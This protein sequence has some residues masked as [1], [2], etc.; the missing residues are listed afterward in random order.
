MSLTQRRRA[1][2]PCRRD[3]C[4]RLSSGRR[5]R[6]LRAICVTEVTLAVIGTRA[7]WTASPSAV[8][9]A[10]ADGSTLLPNG[11]R[12]SPAGKH[13]KVGDL[14][15]NFLQTP[16]S[17]YLIVTT[18]GLARPTFSIIDVASWTVKSAMELDQ[19]WLGLMWAPDGT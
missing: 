3:C 6:I 5:I 17:K 12:L 13:V 1:F 10:L 8:P 2:A 16:S 7:E 9:G 19:A 15:L 18:N 4:P 11:W 14:P